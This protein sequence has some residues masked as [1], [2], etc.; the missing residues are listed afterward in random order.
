MALEIVIIFT[1]QCFYGYMYEKIGIIIALFM[2]GLAGGGALIRNRLKHQQK[3]RF[4]QL[5][6][7]EISICFFS[8]CIP[9]L[10]HAI[11]DIPYSIGQLF[12]T[13]YFF[14]TLVFIIGFLVGMEFPLVCHLL[15]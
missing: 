6:M 11:T 2:M 10:L 7:L 13:E 1:F 3:N 5:T 12:V 8:I 14:Y 15:I 4:I 9:F